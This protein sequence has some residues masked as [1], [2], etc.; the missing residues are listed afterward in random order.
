MCIGCGLVKEMPVDFDIDNSNATG[1]T[2]R[3]KE[4]RGTL[5][6]KP[7][8]KYTRRKPKKAILVEEPVEVPVMAL[9]EVESVPVPVVEPEDGIIEDGD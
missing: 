1:F 3:C 2:A 6:S 8:R 7:K 5:P 9:D 4:C